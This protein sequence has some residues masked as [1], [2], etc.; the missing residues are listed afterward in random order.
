MYRVTRTAAVYDLETALLDNIQKFLL[1]LGNRFCFEARQ[2]RNIHGYG[3]SPY[4]RG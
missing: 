4:P 3:C 1:E 2:K